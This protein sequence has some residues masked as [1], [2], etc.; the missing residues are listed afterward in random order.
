MFSI[1]RK[2]CQPSSRAIGSRL[3]SV[4]IGLSGGVDS[5]VSAYLLKKQGYTVKGVYMRNWSIEEETGIPVCPAKDD[6]V[7]AEQ[8]A[9][10]LDIPLEIYDFEKE[11]WNDV[12]EVC[13]EA[14]KRGETPNPD[15]LCNRYIK[16]A[17]FTSRCFQTGC[18]YVATGH[19][20]RINTGDPI[21]RFSS[22]TELLRGIDRTKDQSYFLSEIDG[23]LLP[24]ILFPVGSLHKSQVKRIA[25]EAGLHVYNKKESMGICFIGERRMKSFLQNYIDVTPGDIYSVN[26]ELLGRHD[27]LAFYT[28]GQGMKLSN[29]HVKYYICEKHVDSNT[30]V[31]CEKMDPRL[32]HSSFEIWEKD[33]AWINPQTKQRLLEY[34]ETHDG[35]PLQCQVR[36]QTSFYPCR[37]EKGVDSLIVK[38]NTLMRAITPGQICVFYDGEVCLGGGKINLVKK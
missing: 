28:I 31:V 3:K 19:Y 17:A 30:L 7:D 2:C 6:L 20:A 12:F 4:V 8:I 13:L 23:S 26:G 35:F 33:M 25:Q 27:G 10:T 34:C 1:V 21:S 22:G 16:F 5:A 9:M 24:R 11:Y 14:Y 38:S 32:F 36:Y 37:L 29:S 18:D 15:V